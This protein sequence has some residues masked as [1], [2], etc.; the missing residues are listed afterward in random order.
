M[1]EHLLNS[2]NTNQSSLLDYASWVGLVGE[3][4]SGV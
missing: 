1:P 4:P 2:A 3:L